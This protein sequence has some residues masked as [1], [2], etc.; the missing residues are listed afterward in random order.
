VKLIILDRDGVINVES[1]A[2]IK[3]PDEWIPI[4][5]SVEAVA[6]LA[7]AGYRVVFATNQSGLAR[8]LFDME[9]L[10]AIHA[11]MRREVTAA[12]GKIDA[13]FICPHGPDDGCLCRKPLPGMFNDIARRY[14]RGLAGVVAIGDSLRDLQ[15]SAAGGCTPWLVRTG[16]GLKTLAK[17]GLPDGTLVFDDLASAVDRLLQDD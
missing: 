6:R 13:I 4:P 7:Q 10:N 2:F 5:G 17:G 8:G 16:N 11:R 12:G 3:T 15:A 9:N 14:D 1:P